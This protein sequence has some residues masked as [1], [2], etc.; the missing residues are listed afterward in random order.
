[1][2]NALNKKGG[3]LSL[4]GGVVVIIIMGVLLFKYVF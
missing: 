4:I 3:L 2:K 1:M